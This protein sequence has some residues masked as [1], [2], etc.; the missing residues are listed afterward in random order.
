MEQHHF[1]TFPPGLDGK[2]S[3]SGDLSP[4]EGSVVTTGPNDSRN[5]IALGIRVPTV[6]ATLSATGVWID[7]EVDGSRYRT[8]LPWL[9]NVCTQAVDAPCDGPDGMN[10]TFPP[11]FGS[12]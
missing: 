3:P 7:Y 2:G 5:R 1:D 12:P 11:E 6:P 9:L 10:F 8:M 4:L